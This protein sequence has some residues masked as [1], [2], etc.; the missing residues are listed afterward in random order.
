MKRIA[1]AL[2]LCFSLTS[3][4]VSTATK[5][6]KTT[7]K[8][9][10]KA[11]KGTVK[12]A[13]WAVKK[14]EGKIDENRLNGDWKLVGV[15]KGDYADILKH[16]ES[17][18]LYQNSCSGQAELVVF[19]INKDK[20]QSLHCGNEKVSWEKIKFNFG[21]NPTS[22]EKEN[23]LTLGKDNHI[24]IIDVSHKNLILEG[25]LDA[26]YSLSGGKVYLF[27]RQ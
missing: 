24:S 19:K 8:V 7:T 1:I 25:N 26:S 5:V 9:A 18:D 13:S 4:V 10:T 17:E 11:V 3:C 27:E 6:V 2:V 12:G 15:Y 20:W 14:A 21:K 22:R 23:Y 16:K